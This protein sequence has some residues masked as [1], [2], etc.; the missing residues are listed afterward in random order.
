VQEHH[1]EVSREVSR[2][3]SRGR[4][5]RQEG[6]VSEPCRHERAI[7]EALASLA[8][9]DAAMEMATTELLAKDV[10]IGR[11]DEDIAGW[12]SRAVDAEATIERVRALAETWEQH[13][14]MCRCTPCVVEHACAADVRAAIEATS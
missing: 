2:K 9:S 7:G 3:T 11:L 10:T 14:P 1:G 4:L 12:I 13:A 5:K 6:V 8:A